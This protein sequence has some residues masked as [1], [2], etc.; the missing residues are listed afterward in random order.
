MNI[1]LFSRYAW[2]IPL[3]TKTGKSIVEAFSSINYKPKKLWVDNGREFYNTLKNCM[4]R[5]IMIILK[6]IVHL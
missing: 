4:I 6:C 2:I 3:K 1:D 5:I